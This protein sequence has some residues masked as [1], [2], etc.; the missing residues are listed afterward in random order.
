MRE[1]LGVYTK[2]CEGRKSLVIVGTKADL[3]GPELAEREAELEAFAQGIGAVAFGVS[4][5]T[6]RNIQALIDFLRS[7]AVALSGMKK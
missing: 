5:K 7:E 6:G 4:A 2:G 3:L 1:T